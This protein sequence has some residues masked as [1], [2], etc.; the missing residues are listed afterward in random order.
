[1]C[2]ACSIDKYLYLCRKYN[3]K[4]VYIQGPVAL[5]PDYNGYHAHDLM[6]REKAGKT[7][8]QS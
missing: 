4:P 2:L 1:M 8:E 3:E 5:V 7:V 6:E